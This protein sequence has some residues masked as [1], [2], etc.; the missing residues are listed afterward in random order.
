MYRLCYVM[1]FCV[2]LDYWFRVGEAEG[3][4]GF[5]RRDREDGEREVVRVYLWWWWE[6]VER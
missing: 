5:K 4:G 3:C 2:Y 6:V 1:I